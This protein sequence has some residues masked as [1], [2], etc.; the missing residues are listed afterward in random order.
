MDENIARY[1]GE[2]AVQDGH[3]AAYVV[4]SGIAGSRDRIVLDAAIEQGRIV[5]TED[6][7]FGSLV[8]QRRLRPDGVVLIRLPRDPE[9]RARRFSYLLEHHSDHLLGSF[10]LLSEQA[11]HI[12]PVWQSE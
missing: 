2:V 5:V 12:R 3:D 1:F 10:V 11:V 7:G 9:M 8:F 4:D 6:L